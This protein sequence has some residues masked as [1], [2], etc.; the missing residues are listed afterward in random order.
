MLFSALPQTAFAAEKSELPF[1][2][3]AY[4]EKQSYEKGEEI[5]VTAAVT[6]NSLNEYNDMRIWLDYPKTEYYLTPGA[7]ERFVES[8]NDYYSGDFRVLEDERVLDFAS[9]FDGVKPIRN[10]S[11]GWLTHTNR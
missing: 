11:F 2:C 5:K 9:K 7:T 6:N 8:F 3:Q 1:T 10:F 4:S